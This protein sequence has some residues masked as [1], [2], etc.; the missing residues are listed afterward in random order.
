MALSWEAA[1]TLM[2]G[3]FGGG[4]LAALLR[5]RTQNRVDERKQLTDEQTAFRRDMAEQLAALRTQV[6]ELS[7]R[8]DDLERDAKEQAKL[9]ARLEQT[10]TFQADQLKHQAEQIRELERTNTALEQRL[11]DL[12]D[13]K[14]QLAQRLTALQLT[15]DVLERENNDLRRENATLRGRSDGAS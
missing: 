11:L 10:N 1:V 8:N 5:A 6:A 15:K 12:V 14:A 13:E 2:V 9:G 4:T 3:L 7:R